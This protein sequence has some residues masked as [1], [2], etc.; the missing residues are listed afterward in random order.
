[1]QVDLVDRLDRGQVFGVVPGPGD[2]RP[3]EDAS[4]F[5]RAPVAEG[6]DAGKQ[7]GLTV[8]PEQLEPGP[9]PRLL[10]PSVAQEAAPLLG[11]D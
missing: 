10:E 5:D 6:V 11:V 2:V 3:A 4:C 7:P 1:M 8:G 9:G